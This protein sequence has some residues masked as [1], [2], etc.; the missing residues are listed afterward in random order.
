MKRSIVLALLLSPLLMF[1]ACK[2]KETAEEKDPAYDARFP[3]STSSPSSALN[4]AKAEM[5]SDYRLEALS[6]Q[7]L[8]RVGSR[9]LSS[10]DKQTLDKIAN[11]LKTQSTTYN[12][13]Q[14]VGYSDPQGDPDRN[15]KLS[16]DRANTVRDYL[17]SRGVN[18]NK[19]EAI[20]KG[21]SSDSTDGM[22]SSQLARDRRV[23]FEIVE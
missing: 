11:E 4:R 18:A 19:L 20:A 7:I 23:Q 21:S 10:S 1:S 9:D 17:I 8:F 14:I 13:L 16:Q 22:S 3:T 5:Q 2:H 12:K 6:Q 15:M